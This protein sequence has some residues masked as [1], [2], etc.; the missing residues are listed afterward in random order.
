MIYHTRKPLIL[1]SLSPRRHDYFRDLGLVFRQE[2]ADLDEQVRPDEEPE[3][4]VKRL[5][6]DKGRSVAVRFPDSYV[7]AADTAV[8]LDQRILGKPA[9]EDEAVAMLLALSGRVHVVRTGFSISCIAA[10]LE[11]VEA[12]ATE[13]TFINLSV[14]LARAYARTGEPRDKAGAYGIQGLGA[15]LVSS[16]RGSY[17]NVVG[18]PLAEIVQKLVQLAVL[19]PLNQNLLDCRQEW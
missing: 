2:G 8:C 15:F 14:D 12:V 9:D 17:S 5:A 3:A 6:R 11:V 19:A 18:L 16:L 7:V 10:N 13:V 1:A 4:Y